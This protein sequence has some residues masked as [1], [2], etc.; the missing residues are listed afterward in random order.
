[1]VLGGLWHGAS[2][3]F[4]VWGAFHGLGLVACKIWQDFVSERKWLAELR[5]NPVWHW[6]GVAMTFYFG[7]FA[8]LLFR[9]ETVGEAMAM[10]RR[11]YQ[12]APAGEVTAAV[13]QSTLPVSILG[14][15]LFVSIK[16]LVERTL[17]ADDTASPLHAAVVRVT[18]LWNMALPVRAM[19]YVA[20][21]I[22]ILGFAPGSISPFIY[23]QF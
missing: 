10:C 23:F 6:T 8:W 11:M 16:E 20:L 18:E 7:V 4:V 9:A 15:T 2:W 21:A 13:L 3:H 5:P 1:M 14:Y 17:S 12:L 22:V 19:T